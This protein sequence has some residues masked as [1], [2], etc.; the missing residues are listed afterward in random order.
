MNCGMYVAS[1]KP[2]LVLA[3]GYPGCLHPTTFIRLGQRRIKTTDMD[4]T[5]TSRVVQKQYS[6]PIRANVRDPSP[7]I[8]QK[9]NTSLSPA[10]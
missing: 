7:T 1:G 9:T 8:L 6:E 3:R 5:L 2:D 4:A 10:P